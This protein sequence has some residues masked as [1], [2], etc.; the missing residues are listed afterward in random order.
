MHAVDELLALEVAHLTE[1]HL[2]AEMIVAVRVAAGAVERT[3]AGDFDRQRGR[4]PGENTA[5]ARRSDSSFNYS[6]HWYSI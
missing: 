3:L 5:P 4:V 2:A 6:S 1:R